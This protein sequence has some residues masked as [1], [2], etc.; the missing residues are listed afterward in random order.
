[1]PF[2]GSLSDIL[3]RREILTTA[4]LFFTIGSIVAGASQSMDI[5]LLGRVLQGVGGAGILPMT[6][7]VLCD[8]VPLRFRPKYASVAQLAWAIGSITGPLIGGLM[9]QHVTWRWIFYLNLPF[10]GVG[11]V[12]VPFIIRLKTKQSSI[13]AKLTRIDWI[14]GFL[15]IGSMTS[16]LMAVTWGGVDHAWDSAATLAP[17]IVGVVGIVAS[18]LWEKWGAREPFIR[19]AIFS[20]RSAL[21]GYYCAMT[22][23]LVVRQSLHDQSSMKY[24][25]MELQL[26]SAVYSIILPIVIL[27]FGQSI[28]A[29]TYRC[30]YNSNEQRPRANRRRCLVA[31]LPDRSYSM[32]P[33]VWLGI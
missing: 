1:M 2:M 32:G 22:Q 10:C 18:I 7:I 28:L 13:M 27:H 14:G 24:A 5:L 12:I 3:G 33:M 9:V 26:L 20:N 16:F 15:F 11:M 23:G 17:L 21:A 19:L 4:L 25:N 31:H 8:I 6:Q 29:R 30:R